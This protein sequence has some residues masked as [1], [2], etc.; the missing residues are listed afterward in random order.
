MLPMI[1]I[2]AGQG[3][4]ASPALADNREKKVEGHGG[5]PAVRML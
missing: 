2:G 1:L 5:C 4:N 3:A